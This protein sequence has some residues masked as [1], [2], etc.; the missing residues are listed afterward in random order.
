[1]LHQDW[2]WLKFLLGMMAFWAIFLTIVFRLEKRTVSPYG[3]LELT[4]SFADTTGYAARW[5]ADAVQAGFVLLGWARDVRGSVYQCSYALLV[6]GDR[7]TFMVISVGTILKIP[8]QGTWL[9]TPAMDGRS[10]NTTDKQ[11]GVQI[12]LSGNWT[13]QLAPVPRFSQLLQKHREWLQSL[14]VLPRG[15]TPNREFVEF[16]EL[17]DQHYRSMERAGL[18][19]F[20]DA[21]ATQFYYTLPGAAKTATWSY[22][23]GLARG[24]SQGSFPRSA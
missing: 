13:N 1:M 8:M 18:L 20:T 16:K 2:F 14:N 5:V 6:S 7:T 15:F 21:S 11:A 22:L 24:L 23:V 9:H 4:P 19:R 10:Y 17:R 3:E 12:D